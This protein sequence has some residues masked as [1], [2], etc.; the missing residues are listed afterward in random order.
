MN[1]HDGARRKH[2]MSEPKGTELRTDLFSR[3]ALARKQPLLE[4]LGKAPADLSSTALERSKACHAN[5]IE[6]Y[7][8]FVQNN[9]QAFLTAYLNQIPSG[10]I[11]SDQQFSELSRTA[12][13]LLH[14]D[15]Q[16]AG[17]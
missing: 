6:D 8:T 5:A 10:T 1:I 2:N 9:A 13:I 14:A 17:H 3:V 12:A 11:K 7:P 15:H 16:L 4:I